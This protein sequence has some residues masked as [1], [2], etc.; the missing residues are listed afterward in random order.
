MDTYWRLNIVK[1]SNAGI[2]ASN[3]K[4]YPDGS[5][6]IL[7]VPL[8]T[9]A[10]DIYT[11]TDFQVDPGD[12]S[13]IDFPAGNP[14]EMEFSPLGEN[15]TIFNSV[16]GITQF[17]NKVAYGHRYREL[18]IV[19]GTTLTTM[20][21]SMQQSLHMT[22]FSSVYL[23]NVTDWNRAFTNAGLLTSVSFGNMSSVTNFSAIFG[24]CSSLVNVPAMDTSS[25]TNLSSMFSGCNSLIT[26]PQLDT[27]NC[28]A[29]NSMFQLT[30]NLTE[31]PIIDTSKGTLFYRMF[32]QSGISSV[33]IIDTSKGTDFWEMFRLCPNLVCISAVNT[34]L[35][36]RTTDMFLQTPLLVAPNASEQTQIENGFNYN[37]PGACP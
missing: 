37:N 33:P 3:N 7:V 23:P 6:M 10:L 25:A 8:E 17:K 12:G 27:S 24:G 19:D 9:F 26:V 4:P 34:L 14:T 15:I 2:F 32:Q 20:S 5:F 35:E 11:D 13:R 31:I 18:S 28:T 22:T 21:Q 36:T 29:F 1:V 16:S 30:T